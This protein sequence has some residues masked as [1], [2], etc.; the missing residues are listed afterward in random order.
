MFR[1]IDA[2]F[3]ASLF[4]C[5]QLYP[6]ALEPYAQNQPK[7]TYIDDY[8]R[9]E[10]VFYGWHSLDD[11]PTTR[12]MRRHSR[13]ILAEDIVRRVFVDT[14]NR[15][16]SAGLRN[17]NIGKQE[18]V[19]E[20]IKHFQ[21]GRK[22][23]GWSA[24]GYYSVQAIDLKLVALCARVKFQLYRQA[25]LFVSPTFFRLHEAAHFSGHLP[26]MENIKNQPT[27]ED[28][29]SYPIDVLQYFCTEDI[30]DVL[31][32]SQEDPNEIILHMWQ[33]VQRHGHHR[34]LYKMFIKR[35]KIISQALSFTSWDGISVDLYR[36]DETTCATIIR[37]LSVAK[38]QERISEIASEIYYDLIHSSY[39][40]NQKS[41]A[42]E[43]CLLEAP[44]T[45][46]YRTCSDNRSLFFDYIYFNHKCPTDQFFQILHRVTKEEFAQFVANYR[47]TTHFQEILFRL[48]L[49]H[50]NKDDT[51]MRALYDAAEELQSRIARWADALQIDSCDV[52]GG[53]SKLGALY[54]F[55]VNKALALENEKKTIS[56]LLD[57]FY[58]AHVMHEFEHASGYQKSS[59]IEEYVKFGRLL[60]KLRSMGVTHIDSTQ[61]HN[62]PTLFGLF[63]LARGA[64]QDILENFAQICSE[65]TQDDFEQEMVHLQGSEVFAKWFGR[66]KKT[67]EHYFEE[68]KH[69]A[70]LAKLVDVG[71]R[72]LML[73]KSL[74]GQLLD[75]L[76]IVPEKPKKGARERCIVS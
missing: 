32:K 30:I 17:S 35:L 38:K 49:E 7:K 59:Y 42:I 71:E 61:P 31:K 43:Q 70:C 15:V 22:F 48:S 18:G 14:P 27:L 50:L 24:H 64:R 9:I 33:C 55:I 20:I 53:E 74:V 63:L 1:L 73:H 2:A 58:S 56:L 41:L 47:K 60:L 4:F 36:E 16:I 65:I 13:T 12:H 46:I 57:I 3:Y 67:I 39:L 37:A 69:L 40:T 21:T 51:H 76:E 6:L 26:Y 11:L 45:D 28:I 52:K 66:N 34:T 23:P 25:Q 68:I 10:P 62:M 5:F 19:L 29:K 44:N 8:T 72:S 54:R 75:E